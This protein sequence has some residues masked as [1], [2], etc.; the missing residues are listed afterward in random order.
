MTLA[1]D[2]PLAQPSPLPFRLPPFEK[3]DAATYREGLWAGMEEQRARLDAVRDDPAPASVENVL[4]AWEDASRLLR[5]AANAF[6]PVQSAD[7]TDELD[8]IYADFLAA[9]A[10]HEDS[11]TQDAGL[12]ARLEELRARADAGEVAL[13]EQDAWALDELIRDFVRNGARLDDEAK[14]RVR[15]LNATLAELYARFER[16]NRN[17]RNAGGF[18]VT[19]DELVGLDDEAIASLKTDGGYRIELLNTT[20]H[21]LLARLDDRDVRRRLYEASVNRALGGEFDN[22]QIIVDI[23]RARA[24]RAQLLGYP[25]H[26]AIVAEEGCARTTEAVNAVMGPLGRAAIA[27]AR[28]E[29]A[30]LESAFAELVPDAQFEAWDWAWT[31]E[32]VRAEKFA[33]DDA[34]LAS[35]LDVHRVLEAVYAAATDLYGITF[36]PRTDLRGHTAD[37]D[38]YEVKNADGT[39]VGLF[40]MDFWARPTKNGGAWMNSLVDQSDLHGELPVVTN[41]CNYLRSTTTITWDG[42][43]TMFHE[44]GHALHGLFAASRYPSR[45]GTSTPRDFVEFPSQV[46]E[47]WAWQPGRVLPAELADKLERASAF[48]QGF[49][50]GEQLAA[51]LLDQAWHQASL[52]DL[53][54]TGDEVEDFERRALERWG[55]A[56]DLVPPRYRSQYFAHIWGNGYAGAYYGYKWSEVMDADA[57]AWFDEHGGGTRDNGDRFRATLLAPGGSVDPMQTWRRFRGRDPEIA[58]LLER[59]GLSVDEG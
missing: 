33:L 29:A 15:E 12:F 43:I 34:E 11:I 31:A 46:N 26:A 56:F 36:T 41:N 58:P 45:S 54:T 44:F 30:E 39:T 20:Q 40:C 23:A 18:D 48:G 51:T 17:A 53:P 13:D 50:A 47:H 5:R 10:A 55:V 22:R 9:S 4:I 59:L 38:V 2:H 1:T 57:V 16:N 37:A 52:D 14:A 27:K 42:V 6:F 24:E 35:Y 25:H 3:L 32:R 28:L 7:T 21:P 49:A 19:R 8:A